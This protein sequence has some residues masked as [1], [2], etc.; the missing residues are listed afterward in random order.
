[1]PDESIY[2]PTNWLYSVGIMDG[3]SRELAAGLV[4][5]YDIEMSPHFEGL[6]E[7]LAGRLAVSQ[8][9][10]EF[11]RQQEAERRANYDLVRNFTELLPATPDVSFGDSWFDGLLVDNA[12]EARQVRA[13]VVWLREPYDY[14]DKSGHL[15]PYYIVGRSPVDENE[16]DDSKIEGSHATYLLLCSARR[17]HN[18]EALKV[19]AVRDQEMKIAETA[20]QEASFRD[21][22]PEEVR[23]M[24]HRDSGM[25]RVSSAGGMR[26]RLTDRHGLA[27]V[28]RWRDP[29]KQ[30]ERHGMSAMELGSYDMRIDDDQLALFDVM[31]T[32]SKLAVTFGKKDELLSLLAS[33]NKIPAAETQG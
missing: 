5:V 20:V 26:T 7:Q 4:N 23:R 16:P 8:Q 33:Y 13:N 31:T 19:V 22:E 30:V 27:E 15:V 28:A 21:L 24:F 18:K 11:L 14:T 3:E 10:V 29:V 1:M 9:T 25:L 2:C 17:G 12:H 6:R 32:L